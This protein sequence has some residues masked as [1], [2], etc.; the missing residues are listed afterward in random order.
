LKDDNSAAQLSDQSNRLIKD[1][2][3]ICPNSLLREILIPVLV[4]QPGMLAPLNEK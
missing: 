2:V 1:I 4:D 3:S